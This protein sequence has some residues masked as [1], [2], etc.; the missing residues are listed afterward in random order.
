MKFE[1][2]YCFTVR[3]TTTKVMTDEP[4]PKPERNSEEQS[5]EPLQI[6]ELTGIDMLSS[7]ITELEG[8]ISQL[9]DQLLRKAAEFENYKKRVESDSA[10][11]IRFANEDLIMSMLPVLDD[12]ERSLKASRETSPD[13]N[14]GQQI[15]VRGI[16]LI[17]NKFR[18]ILDMQGVKSFE[19]VGKPFDP[20][21]HDALMQILNPDVPPHTVLEEVEKGYMMNDRV[22]R[23]AKVIVSADS[24][25]PDNSQDQDIG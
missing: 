16:E 9:K 5:S 1:Q 22:L 21:L 6:P 23:H 4:T 20:H 18:K 24:V 7:R 2:K 11:L 25:A 17:Y 13:D 19:V 15:I 12:F 3:N 8:T 14:A 10:N